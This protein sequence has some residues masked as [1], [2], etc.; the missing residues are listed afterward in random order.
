MA[1]PMRVGQPPQYLTAFASASPKRVVAGH[2][3]DEKT[4]LFSGA[5]KKAYRLDV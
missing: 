5:A 1:Y 2:S 4:A 3:G